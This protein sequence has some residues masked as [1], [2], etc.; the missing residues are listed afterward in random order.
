[1]TFLM[2]RI[3][4]A[5]QD[6]NSGI[7]NKT[8]KKQ[9]GAFGRWERFLQ[10]CEIYDPFL[11]TFSK[12]SRNKIIHAFAYSTRNNEFGKTSKPSLRGSTVESTI[13]HVV[14][15][16]REANKGNPT[17]DEDGKK[18]LILSRMLRG[19]NDS[20]PAQSKQ[21]CLPLQIFTYLLNQKE[22][23]KQIATAQ[24]ATGALFF[25]MRSCEYLRVT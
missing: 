12:S 5:K 11:T 19:Y 8:R 1:M 25:A 4:A 21:A 6:N 7:S 3:S 23:E 14:A 17:L 20:D 16:F 2:A 10:Q 15:T 13:N 18:C 24:L 22:S 9:S